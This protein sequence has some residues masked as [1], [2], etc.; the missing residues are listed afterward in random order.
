MKLSVIM[1]VYN[2]E[3]CLP[4]SLGSLLPYVDECIIV[5]GS[6]N[7][8]S[9]DSTQAIV[10]QFA[11][12]YPGII[13]Y[14]SGEFVRDDGAWDDTAQSNMAFGMVT[15]D[16]VMRT[17]ADIIYERRSMVMLR[18]IVE[19]HLDKRYFYCPLLEFFYDTD[20]I[21]LPSHLKV[22]SSLLRPMCGD[23]AVIAMSANPHFEDLGEHRRS[24]L[25][26]TIDWKNDL[27]YM[28]HVRRFHYSHVK[29]FKEEVA[30][31]VKYI[32]RGDFETAGADLLALGEQSVWDWAIKYVENYKDHPQLRQYAGV[33]PREAE[34][35]RSMNT[36]IG[37]DEF[38]GN[39]KERWNG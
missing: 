4:Y 26:A 1:E 29:P 19:K 14:V 34:A 28:P 17:H 27:I 31:I 6:E 8:P 23:V 38:M 12:N 30:K 13:I 15:G 33:Y 3:L 21:M 32:K 9:T 22:E 25:C 5:D 2:E 20:H 24:S 7:G 11:G 16:F 36:M 10:D 18:Q 39:Y 35:L 37:H